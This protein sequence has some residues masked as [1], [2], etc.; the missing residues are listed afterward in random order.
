[1]LVNKIKIRLRGGAPF[2]G[3]FTQI[4]FV[5]RSGDE[6]NELSKF[7][8][9][10]RFMEKIKEIDVVGLRA[11]VNLEE[12]INCSLEH[13]GVV[14][15]DH[16]NFWNAVPARLST[17]SNGS[18]HYIVRDEEESLKLRYSSEFRSDY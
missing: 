8:L 4:H 1:M 14:D 9:V 18:I 12:T 6:I 3:K 10:R 2:Q 15:G 16:A 17:P 5:L 11:E 13:E 7:C